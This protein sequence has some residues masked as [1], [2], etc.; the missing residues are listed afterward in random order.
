M[1]EYAI[2]TPPQHGTW[3]EYL[4]VWRAADEAEVYE[5]GLEF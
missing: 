3:Q 2:K 4:D 1:V 5:V